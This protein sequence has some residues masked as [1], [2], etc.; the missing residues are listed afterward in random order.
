MAKK[1]VSAEE[2]KTRMLELFYE[3]GECYQLKVCLFVF[4]RAI[5]DGGIVLSC[6]PENQHFKLLRHTECPFCL[7]TQPTRS[8]LKIFQF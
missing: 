1:G 8:K 7:Q 4:A 5:Y 3:T 6:T 2:K